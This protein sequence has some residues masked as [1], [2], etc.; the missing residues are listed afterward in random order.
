MI[1]MGRERIGAATEVEVMGEIE[2]V[3]QKL[4]ERISIEGGKREK[5]IDSGGSPR[6]QSQFC[7]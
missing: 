7:S 3:A 4:D 1:Q 2:S 5:K 6:E